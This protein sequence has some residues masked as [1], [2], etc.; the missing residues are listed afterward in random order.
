MKNT[1]KYKSLLFLFM[2]IFSALTTNAQFYNGHQMSFGKNRVQFIKKYWRYHRYDKFDTY[3]YKNGDSLSRKIA[4][5][6]EKKLPD[7]ENF[8]G[9]G[10]Q[11]RVIFVCFKR[12]SDFRE[13]NIGYKSDDNNSNIGGKTRIIDNKIFVYYEGDNKSLEKQIIEGITQLLINEML[14]GGSYTKKVANSTLID[15]PEWY[16]SGLISYLSEEW[17]FDIENQVKD[18]FKSKKY[19]KINRLIGEEAKYAGHSFWYFIGQTYGKDVIPNII[20][21]TRIN[22][23]SDVGF[24]YVLGMSIKELNPL[25]KEFFEAKYDDDFERKLP[26][27]TLLIYKGKRNRVYQ[28]V[29]ISPDGR[30]IAYVENQSGRY[31]IKIFDKQKEKTKTIRKKG[32]KLDQITDYSYPVLTWHPSSKI[33]T[34]FTE[35][36]GRLRMY[37][38]NIKN[39]DLTKRNLMYFDKI[40]SADYSN[41]GFSLALSGVKD[42]KTNIYIYNTTAG[43][44]KQITNDAYI[45][46][47]P[48]FVNNSTKIIFSSDRNSNTDNIDTYKPKDL[49]IY[50]LEDQSILQ[51][52]KTPYFNDTHPSE[53][54]QNTYLSLTDET[55]I[56]GR[57]IIKFDSA[58]S[59]I[60]TS[61]HYRYFANNFLNSNYSR[62]IED[63]D[64]NKRKQTLAE[65]IFHNK[66]FNIYQEKISLKKEKINSKTYFRQ[67]Y[68]EK[69][70][71]KDSINKINEQI[72]LIQKLELDSLKNNPPDNLLHPDSIP[73]DINNYIFETEKNI[74]Y[75]KINPII[76]TI[77]EQSKDTTNFLPTYNYLTNFY[78]NYLTQQ[79]DF[80]TLSDSYQL[81]TGDAFYFSP[82]INVFTKIGI[83]DL[84]E[85]YRVSG[86]FR[87]GASLNNFEYLLSLENLKYKIDKQYIY[88]R[89][90][91]V[92]Q[93]IDQSGQ[94]YF[95]LKLYSNE[96]MY[97]LK[98]PFNQVSSVKATLSL[99]HDK[100]IF[101]ALERS[102]LAE[103]SQHQF[104]SGIKLE[105]NFDNIKSLGLNLNEGTRFKLFSEYYQEVDQEYTNMIVVGADFRYYKKIH[106]NL[107]FA[108]RTAASASFGKSRLLYYLGGVDNWY[109]F[110]PKKLRFDNSVEINQEQ[111]YVYQAVATNMRGFVQN[112]RNGTNFMVINN[113]IRFP[114]I[115]Y[116][117][118][119]P[120]NSAFL[121]NFQIV[122]F[123]D[124]G[125]AWSGLT[126]YDDANAYKTEIVRR[127]P[128]TVVIDKN[129]WPVVFGY[130]FGLRSKI[131]GYFVRLDWAWGIDNDVVLPRVF[132]FSLNLDF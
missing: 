4:R 106:R 43:N 48:K 68:T 45:D 6:A 9:Y 11:K 16:Q 78:T 77:S 57:Q 8:F 52:T 46:I 2:L 101:L 33:I 66:R 17:S 128:V 5:I 64:V 49:F 23:S 102:T 73:I 130:G 58:V 127:G 109:T 19:K 107:I 110:N 99:R 26:E 34:F 7:V 105:Y 108:S 44:F 63:F 60:D 47:D 69:L 86:A 56:T 129:R 72:S 40:L 32:H 104:F 118:N 119:R 126:P 50:N 22:K 29:K 27:E 75:Y 112:A 18:G 85:D 97:L 38:Y 103:P 13:S 53:I 98:Y 59:Y 55:G 87:M 88:H 84:F 117:I 21:L 94:F 61:I 131:L 96:F 80:G 1:L 42:G 67:Q 122:G 120:L 116:L 95:L 28:R 111:N 82:G 115:R 100:A 83:F 124:A 3:Y 41:N 92:N 30:Y 70:A 10:L 20:Y 65:L 14:Y 71:Y 125:S 121:N 76:D 79:V 24:R 113:E 62:N 36:Q 31:K 39:K 114:I 12:L 132:Y 35:E 15:L 123:A 93:I 81:Y 91:Y 25:W 37:F 74:Q 90:T 89:Q 54:K 51:L